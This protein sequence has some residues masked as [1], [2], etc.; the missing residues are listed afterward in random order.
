MV[1]QRRKAL[2]SR[3][4]DRIT[5]RRAATVPDG[6]GGFSRAWSTVAKVRAEVVSQNGREAVIAGALQGVSSYRITIRRRT[7]LKAGD[8]ILF[9]RAGATEAEELNIKAPPTDD[10]FLP[11]AATVI[12]ADSDA[13]QGA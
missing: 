6:R 9:R 3:L 11:Q 13:P 2:A 7:D 12:Y 1:E 10:P 5:I 8:Q 4:R